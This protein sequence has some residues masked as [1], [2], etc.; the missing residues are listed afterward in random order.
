MPPHTHARSHMYIFIYLCNVDNSMIIMLICN[1]RTPEQYTIMY[2]EFNIEDIVIYTVADKA[3][4][5]AST[6]RPAMPP[7]IS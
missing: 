3:G 5:S 2:T 4:S 1:Q 6:C 7:L